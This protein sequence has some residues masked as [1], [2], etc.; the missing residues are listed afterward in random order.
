MLFVK[1]VKELEY[2]DKFGVMINQRFFNPLERYAYEDDGT[3]IEKLVDEFLLKKVYTLQTVVTNTSGTNLELQ[4]LMDVPSG[5]IPLMSHEYVQIINAN[6]NSFSTT[7]F[8]RQFY[9]PSEGTYT[10]YPANASRNNIVI[11]KAK[12]LPSI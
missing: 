8:E 10:L 4:L 6:V 11:A 1:E 12:K 9:F 2:T 5:A 7:S 3:Q